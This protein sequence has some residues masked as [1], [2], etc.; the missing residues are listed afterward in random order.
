MLRCPRTRP[1]SLFVV[2]CSCLGILPLGSSAQETASVDSSQAKIVDFIQD[3]LPIFNK[4]CLECHEG[5]EAK[6]G[7]DIADKEAVLGYITSGSLANSTL[8]TDY[9]IADRESADSTA[10]PP[11][12]KEK[13]SPSELALLRVWIE[14]GAVWKE[15]ATI[16]PVVDQAPAVVRSFPERLWIFVGY[17]HPAVVHFPIALLSLGAASLLFSFFT[18]KRAEDFAVF[19]LVFGALSSIASVVLGWSFASTQG[20][21]AWNSGFS[22]STI[23]WHRWLGIATTLLSCIAALSAVL[24]RKRPRW[25]LVWKIGLLLVAVLIGLVGHQGGELKYGEEFFHQAFEDLIK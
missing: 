15:P 22:N 12:S 19:C 1:V 17:F 7:F 18:G 23:F 8:W 6:G 9:L 24:L 16:Q 5:S 10:M 3:I 14:E 20:Y 25:N 4:R 11:A 13:L 2:I 21:P